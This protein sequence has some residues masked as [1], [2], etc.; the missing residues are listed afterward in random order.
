MT[1][2]YQR[3]KTPI[4]GIPIEKLKPKKVRKNIRLTLWEKLY[5]FEVARGMYITTRH[6]VSNMV[7]FFVHPKGKKRTIFTVYYPEE[8]VTLPPAYRGRPVLVA[9]KDGRE[10]C[11]ACG[12]CEKI[13]PA[14]A[15]S[16]VAGERSPEDRFPASYTLDLSRCVYCGYCEEVCPKEAIVMSSEYQGLADRD[17]SN[18]RCSKEKLLRSEESV[19]GRLEYIR[20]IYSKCSY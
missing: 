6:F 2:S 15:I 20:R 18:M 4:V 19:K 1:D 9:R 16:I 17:R 3:K 13:C 14:H 5:V 7:G 12:L 11:V 8:K 10:K